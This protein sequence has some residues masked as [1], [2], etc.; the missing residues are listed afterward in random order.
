MWRYYKASPVFV[1]VIFPENKVRAYHFFETSLWLVNY[2][3]FDIP[4]VIDQL[5]A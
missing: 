2:S 3:I 1:I 5:F 4:A